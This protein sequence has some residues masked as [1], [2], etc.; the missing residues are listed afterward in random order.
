MKFFIIYGVQGTPQSNWFQWLKKELEELGHQIFIPDFP[1]PENQTLDNW[2]KVI[3]PF[4]KDFNNR[5][6]ILIG[7]SLGALFALNI[8]EKWT[9][10]ATFLVGGFAKLPGNRFDPGMTTFAKDFNWNKIHQNC[11]NFYIF[12]GD[13]DKYVKIE[14]A[15]D[16]A[17]KTDGE[18]TIIKNGGHLNKS[19]GF[20]QFPELLQKIKSTI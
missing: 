3:E 7:H 13:N 20:V 4:S 12:H 19:A 6:T 1:T 10:K 16:L 5:E 18:L 2:L 9:V 14:T 8:I 17:Q 11:Q 15:E